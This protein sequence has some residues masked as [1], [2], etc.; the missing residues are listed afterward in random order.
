MAYPLCDRWHSG[1]T[2]P[3][4]RLQASIRSCVLQCQG[5]PHLLKLVDSAVRLPIM[6]PKLR[7]NANTLSNDFKDAWSACAAQLLPSAA[8]AQA[9]GSHLSTYDTV[10]HKVYLHLLRQVT[11]PPFGY[12]TP[13]DA[14]RMAKVVLRAV[15]HLNSRQ[16]YPW[17]ALAA[18]AAEEAPPGVLWHTSVASSLR[19]FA[20]GAARGVAAAMPFAC[21][22][23]GN[24]GS[25]RVAEEPGGDDGPGHVAWSAPLQQDCPAQSP[26]VPQ[27]DSQLLADIDA[28]LLLLVQHRV[29]QKRTFEDGQGARRRT[30]PAQMH[31]ACMSAHGSCGLCGK[32]CQVHATTNRFNI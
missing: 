1:S 13:T 30:R 5:S 7:S 23:H 32:R 12:S 26:F 2:H 8:A 3:F 11:A 6:D 10:I 25:V 29:L 18:A 24:S 9:A 31:P 20:G 21:T 22:P 27:F 19:S 28:A 15:V 16:W 17:E 4:A 14:A